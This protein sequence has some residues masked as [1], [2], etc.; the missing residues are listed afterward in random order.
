LSPSSDEERTQSHGGGATG[1][2]NCDGTAPVQAFFLSSDVATFFRA[3]T[4]RI[5]NATSVASLS[6]FISRLF[7]DDLLLHCHLQSGFPTDRRTL[8]HKQNVKSRTSSNRSDCNA[9][10]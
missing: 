3:A 7:P 5:R 2:D 1:L 10:K 8:D 9:E 6:I 4:A